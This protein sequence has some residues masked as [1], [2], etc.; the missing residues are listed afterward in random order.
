MIMINKK[1]VKCYLFLYILLILPASTVFALIPEPSNIIYGSIT[2]DGEPITA[3]DTHVSLVLY[4]GDQV[5]AKYTMGNIP[6]MGNNYKL[7]VL[8]DSILTR[9]VDSSR[10]GDELVI[11]YQV[12]GKNLAVANVFIGERG[13]TIELN[14]TLRSEFIE[15]SLD[16]NIIDSDGDGIPDDV[17]ISMGL[18]PELSS[19][20]LLDTDGDG[21]N[22]LQEYANGTNHLV[23]DYGPSLTAPSDNIFNATGLF[24][25]VNLGDAVAYDS[26]DGDLIAT[27]DS[28]KFY[29]PG[30]YVINWMASDAAG[31]TASDIQLI[32]V[33][34]M[35]SF[36][37]DQLVVE[38]EMVNLAVVLNGKA[39]EYPVI[40]P[41]T[42]SGTALSG[43]V[44]FT[45][46]EGEIII[47]SGLSASP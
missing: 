29:M 3:V 43:G 39:I 28:H 2:I 24:T 30:E 10:K 1:I 18:D 36:T 6:T 31:N 23:D 20:A 34:P 46:V 12:A 7:E 25:K 33:I 45:L 38:G 35:V 44:D 14:L 19:D 9:N 15:A 37:A 42:V 27:D 32:T 47:N 5:V 40:V 8:L 22:N 13:E 11:R 41:Y 26:K 16:P 4:S 21:V 17:E